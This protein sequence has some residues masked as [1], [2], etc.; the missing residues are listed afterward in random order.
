MTCFSTLY[1]PRFS[2][3][4]GFSPVTHDPQAGLAASAASPP[5][6]KA[7]ETALTS[8]D[9]AVTGL[10]PGANESWIAFF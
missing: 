9:T 5:A 3:A 6:A 8:K 7:V 1:K 4:P 10:K 2:L